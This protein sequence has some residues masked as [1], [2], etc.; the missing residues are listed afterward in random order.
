[1]VFCTWYLVPVN[2]LVP[3]TWYP[4]TGCVPVGKTVL[5]RSAN[6]A[7]AAAAAA[8]AA[9]PSTRY[10]VPGTSSRQWWTRSKLLVV[11]GRIP[12]NSL[13]TLFCTTFA[14]EIAHKIHS[15]RALLTRSDNVIFH[16]HPSYRGGHS[17]YDWA[18]FAWLDGETGVESIVLGQI[19][20]FIELG[21]GPSSIN[22]TDPRLP[23]SLRNQSPGVFAIIHSCKYASESLH[24]YSRLLL[25][26]DLTLDRHG[27]KGLLFVPV[28]CIH[29]P[30][31]VVPN[32][33]ASP[34]KVIQ[35]KPQSAWAS[36]FHF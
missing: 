13:L 14:L 34:G 9:V 19:Y 3:G 10:Q 20:G 35:I 5:P 32:L 15:H 8:A 7:A 27:N 1:M 18:E 16:A 17:W 2:Y 29:S 11:K 23:S 22:F 30:A 33:G 25:G 26:A 36:L 4:N 28:D 24:N 12:L 31:V 6:P 21:L